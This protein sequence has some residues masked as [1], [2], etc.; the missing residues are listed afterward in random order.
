MC[1]KDVNVYG[2]YSK[3]WQ[4]WEGL[5]AIDIL[6]S[7]FLL[8]K[9]YLNLTLSLSKVWGAHMTQ[10]LLCN[11]FNIFFESH[12]LVDIEPLK[13]VPTWRKFRNQ[14]YAISK[15]LDRFFQL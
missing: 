15:C 10:D 8:L 12:K 11:Y 9:G 4:Y 3:S 6:D 14:K 1:L 7:Q 5:A 2:P 13:L